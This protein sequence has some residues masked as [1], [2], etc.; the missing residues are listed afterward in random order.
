[1]GRCVCE[2]RA[3]AVAARKHHPTRTRRNLGLG[4][5]FPACLLGPCTGGYGWRMKLREVGGLLGKA[6]TVL[7][8]IEN[9]TVVYSSVLSRRDSLHLC[10]TRSGLVFLCRARSTDLAEIVVVCSGSEYPVELLTLEEGDVVID[11]G[12]NVGAFSILVGQLNP[13]TQFRGI[14][15]EP[16]PSNAWLCGLNLD[17][18]RESRFEI[19]EVA[20]GAEAR[21][22]TMR[23]DGAYDAV[24][25]DPDVPG[26]VPIQRLSELCK[27]R[28]ISHIQLLKLD[29]EGAEHDVLRSDLPF[30][31]ASVDRILLEVH[32]LP[33]RPSDLLLDELRGPFEIE[34]VGDR[35]WTGWNRSQPASGHVQA[36]RR[37][38]RR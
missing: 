28:N 20:L 9:P 30:I 7:Q 5:M 27:D 38:G 18:N 4:R 31:A 13:T 37:A 12:A 17:L 6:R 36:P 35:I 33:G 14:A 29:C 15:V 16:L 19:S 21:W 2:G 32:D 24:S 1:M 8:V 23:F 3:E 10:R 25:I 11:V 26:N 22:G 34:E